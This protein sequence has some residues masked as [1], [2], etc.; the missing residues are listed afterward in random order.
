MGALTPAGGDLEGFWRTITS[1]RSA[2]RPLQYLDC[3]E[4][5]VTIGGEVDD[6]LFS[7]QERPGP[8]KKVDRALHLAMCAAGRA[9]RD[10]GLDPD[11]PE[12]K[13]VAVV[14]GSGGGPT[15][16]AEEAYLTYAL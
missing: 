9:L 16:G 12:P 11:A 4:Y 14:L 6:A 1:G 5:P 7:E 8:M 15:Q 13:P 2:L 3:S 10:A